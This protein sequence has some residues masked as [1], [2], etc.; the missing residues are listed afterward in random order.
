MGQK[1][2]IN[3]SRIEAAG[4]FSLREYLQA[5]GEYN[6]HHYYGHQRVTS[7]RIRDYGVLLRLELD[8]NRN[9]MTLP[10][11]GGM[12]Y[13]VCFD[14]VR[15]VI[16]S[17]GSQTRMRPG[18]LYSNSRIPE[19]SVVIF[20]GRTPIRCYIMLIDPDR[21]MHAVRSRFE[22]IEIDPAAVFA[23][24]HGHREPP[25]LEAVF[26]QMMRYRLT[27]I[28]KD[29]FYECKYNEVISLL[30]SSNVRPSRA[31]NRPSEPDRRT[32][33]RIA[34]HISANIHRDPPI[35][36][37]SRMALMSTSKFSR[38]FKQ[39]I[40]CTVTDYKENARLSKAKYLLVRTDDTITAVAMAVGYKKLGNFNSFFYKHTKMT[41]REYRQAFIRT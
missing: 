35:E 24:L 1:K 39:V 3:T 13:I 28:A 22:D 36:E 33:F 10:D 18:V 7:K 41:P 9:M 30:I 37:L 21:Y 23:Q 4:T 19:D 5:D 40:G 38:C 12:L 34:D 8:F 26:D 16:E 6:E 20:A 15:G 25:E 32:M 2:V 31:E 29:M 11:L 14:K 27:G 17:S